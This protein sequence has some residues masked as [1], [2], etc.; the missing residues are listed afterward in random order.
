MATA[1]DSTAHMWLDTPFKG[2]GASWWHKAL[3]DASADRAAHQGARG[4]GRHRAGH[5]GP[6]R[7]IIP[8]MKYTFRNTVVIALGGSIVHP[9]GIDAVYLKK[10]KAFLAPLFKKGTG[11]KRMKFVMVVGGGTLSRRFQDAAAQVANK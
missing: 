9:D 11:G 10:F 5:D 2:K 6:Y 4:H 8:F 3:L 7:A 1:K